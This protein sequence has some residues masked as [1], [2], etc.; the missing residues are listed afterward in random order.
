MDVDGGS[1]GDEDVSA[2]RSNRVREPAAWDA[3]DEID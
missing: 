1:H 2:A 3:G